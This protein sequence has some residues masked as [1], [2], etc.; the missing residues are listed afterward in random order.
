VKKLFVFGVATAALMLMPAIVAGQAIYMNCDTWYDD[1]S[2]T[3]YGYN[4]TSTDYAFDFYYEAQV[5][6]QLFANGQFV[7]D[8]IA[9]TSGS[10]AR[11]EVSTPAQ[12]D[13]EYFLNGGT[14]ATMYYY[15][16]IVPYYYYYDFGNF[17]YLIQNDPC[18]GLLFRVCVGP[19]PPIWIPMVAGAGI[20]GVWD[21]V[22]VPP[23]AHP[24]ALTYSG[25]NTVGNECYF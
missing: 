21:S 5:S 6:A 14:Y 2:N 1:I 12:P 20:G 19:G 22:Y 9:V 10:Y 7:V 3:V 24:T 18:F 16:Y 23:C 15:Q 8:D 11:A 4:E 13:T 17:S 25:Y